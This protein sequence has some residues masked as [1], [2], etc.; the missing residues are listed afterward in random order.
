MAEI[1]ESMADEESKKFMQ[2]LI[3]RRLQY[4]MRAGRMVESWA[5]EHPELLYDVMQEYTAQK[6]WHRLSLKSSEREWVD[7]G[8]RTH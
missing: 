7:Q 8:A 3:L 1:R 5:R 6:R 4:E 2:Q